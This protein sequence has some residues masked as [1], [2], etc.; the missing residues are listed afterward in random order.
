MT[1]IAALDDASA[2]PG[3]LVGAFVGDSLRGVARLQTVQGASRPVAFL[4]AYAN[5]ASGETLSFRVFDP[6]SEQVRALATRQAFVADAALG[7][8][9]APLVLRGA[10]ATAVD[11]L[12]LPTAFSVDALAPN[13]F[14]SQA[15]LRY[16]LPSAEQVRIEVV[17]VMGRRVAV[18]ADARQEAG[19]YAVV[20]DGSTLASGVYVVTIRAG[21]YH[22]TVRVTRVR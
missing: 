9:A 20:L 4:M 1:M 14:A 13:P 2:A 7:T 15:V 18:L 11:A 5:A 8:L 21:V 10:S 19:R 16:A 22:Q 6:A 12:A 3:M 17:D